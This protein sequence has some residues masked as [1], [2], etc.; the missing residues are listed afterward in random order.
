MAASISPDLVSVILDAAFDE[1]A[2]MRES[3]VSLRRSYIGA[4]VFINAIAALALSGHA[5]DKALSHLRRQHISVWRPGICRLCDHKVARPSF[6][7]RVK[8]PMPPEFCQEFCPGC[9]ARYRRFSGRHIASGQF[10]KL[11]T[12]QA[13]ELRVALWLAL[14]IK[15]RTKTHPVRVR[16]LSRIAPLLPRVYDA[17]TT[18]AHLPLHAVPYDEW[19]ESQG[20]FGPR[21]VSKAP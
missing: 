7:K 5:P 18:A 14:E 8:P 1:V 6:F 17:G 4:R 12:P 20:D 16:R 2:L 19:L 15:E 21:S 10:D 11:Q 3:A 13:T 9:M